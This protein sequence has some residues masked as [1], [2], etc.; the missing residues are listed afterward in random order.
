MCESFENDPT[1]LVY[2]DTSVN[3]HKILGQLQVSEF[4]GRKNAVEF[5]DGKFFETYLTCLRIK[6][7]TLKNFK[8]FVFVKLKK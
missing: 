5:D 7:S 2:I 8:Y 6:N 3:P 4:G 1:S